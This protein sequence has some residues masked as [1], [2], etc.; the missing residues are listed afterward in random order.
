MGEERHVEPD[1]LRQYATLAQSQ[2]DIIEQD[3][4]PRL[5]REGALGKE[6]AFGALDQSQSAITQYADMHQTAWSNL[7]NFRKNLYGLLDVIQASL[8]NY[9]EA[10]EAGAEGID[11]TAEEL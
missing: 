2:L 5:R 7:Q 6:P 3:L 8:D 1:A 10:D 9:A 4:I 11:K